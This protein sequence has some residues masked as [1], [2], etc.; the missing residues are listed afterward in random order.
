MG[1]IAWGE[2]K[3]DTDGAVDQFEAA[4]DTSARIT[5]RARIFIATG[6]DRVRKLMRTAS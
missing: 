1:N 5:S 2:A 3:E 4:G 6:W